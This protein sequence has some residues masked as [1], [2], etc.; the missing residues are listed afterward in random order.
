MILNHTLI[1]VLTGVKSYYKFHID[2]SESVT[3]MEVTE[4]GST[5]EL[6]PG[7]EEF[8]YLMDVARNAYQE[9][10]LKNEK[11]KKEMPKTNKATIKPMIAELESLFS[12]L[13]EKYF[14]GELETP[15][16]TIAPDTCRAY[17]WF[18]TWRAWQETDNKEPGED[19]GYYEIN[20]TSD[21]LDRDPVDISSTLLHEMVHLYNKMRDIQ[22]C[23]RGGKYHNAK[24]RDAAQSHGLLVEKDSTY[25]F[26]TTKPTEE[27]AEYFRSLDLKFDLYRPSTTEK[28]NRGD[29]SDNSDDKEKPKKKSS[30]RKYVCP[31]CG[32]II[33]ATKEVNVLCG[34]CGVP[35]EEVT[36]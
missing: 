13:N 12:K 36:D 8:S 35:F 19:D 4:S 23:S 1:N 32:T 26:S 24:F 15:V 10:K 5:R 25:G 33:R 21:Y 9:Y 14:D 6:Y 2:D 31:E 18:T 34:D 16:I 3:K 27:T 29:E 17:G 30:T 28:P 20:I 11:E 22:D 7:T